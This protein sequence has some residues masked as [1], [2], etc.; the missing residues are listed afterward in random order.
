[1]TPIRRHG[2][3]LAPQ[4]APP[5]AAAEAYADAA[6]EASAAPMP[7][8]VVQRDIA[9]GPGPWQRFDI[10]APPGNVD[11]R[12]PVLVFLHGGGWQSGYKEW[13]GFMA[14]TVAALGAVLVA[15]TYRLAPE[16]RFPAFLLDTL[17][18]LAALRGEV[19]RFGG[20]PDRLFLSGHSAGGH[21]AAMAALRPD[22]GEAAGLPRG[23]IRGALP[24]SGI[25]DLHHPA[26]AP[27]SLE[28]LVYE[29]ILT[30]PEDDAEASPVHWAAQASVPFFLAWGEHDTERV[31]RSNL[32]MA[33]RL[34]AAGLPHGTACYP[35][36]DHFGTHLAL[37]DPSHPWYMELR[38]MLAG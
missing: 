18:A 1:M 34:R 10:F 24:L 9:W 28:A 4:P 32:L 12:R 5:V 17:G 37:R 25:L 27:G 14:P 30:R 2:F 35:G 29:N 22:L 16:H 38:R 19:G 20:D 33:E 3:L 36:L 11:A 15:P 13:C 7:G 8:L 23:V 26:P 31:R 21:L 6:L